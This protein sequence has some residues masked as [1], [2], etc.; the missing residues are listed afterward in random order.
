MRVKVLGLMI[1]GVLVGGLAVQADPPAKPETKT[2]CCLNARA[3][4]RCEAGE[5]KAKSCNAKANE[6]CKAKIKQTGSSACEKTKDSAC[7]KSAKAD[8]GC[9]AK[10]AEPKCC[11]AKKAEPKCCETKT[12]KK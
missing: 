2:A 10:K 4:V 6:C 3:K 12:A 11:E 7:G 8:D 9:E 1:L 5:A